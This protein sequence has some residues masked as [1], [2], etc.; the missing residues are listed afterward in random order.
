MGLR[1]G[2]AVLSWATGVFQEAATLVATFAFH[3]LKVHR[4]EARAV[5]QNGRGHGALQK[6]G[7]IAEAVLA[8]IVQAGR[9]L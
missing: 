1:A 8:K 4:L 7:A 2:R 6:L 5:S 3:E 9:P